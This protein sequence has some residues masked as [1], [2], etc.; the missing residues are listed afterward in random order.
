MPAVPGQGAEE[1]G[2]LS[3]PQPGEFGGSVRPGEVGPSEASRGAPLLRG[4]VACWTFPAVPEISSYSAF[5][6]IYFTRD[7]ME[8]PV[9]CKNSM[10]PVS[11]IRFSDFGARDPGGR[12][13][14]R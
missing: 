2:T 1:S 11:S 14:N 9:M 5:L 8:R 3:V 10:Q 13:S 4:P 7:S 6:F 12:T